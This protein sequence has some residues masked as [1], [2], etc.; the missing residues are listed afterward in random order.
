MYSTSTKKNP[1]TIPVVSSISLKKV[2]SK[3]RLFPTADDSR[4]SQR[5]FG[6]WLARSQ[7]VWARG[8]QDV[9]RVGAKE[10]LK[11]ACVQKS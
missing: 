2:G 7:D 6:G 3:V 5:M 4:L 11:R 8:H 9:S 10:A 1:L